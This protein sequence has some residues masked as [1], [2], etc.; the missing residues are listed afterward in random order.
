L[1]VSARDTT[2]PIVEIVELMRETCPGWDYVQL[3]EGGHMA[4][5]SH[6]E[7][8]NPIIVDFIYGRKRSSS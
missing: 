3:P 5:M 1:V 8:V 4:P 6:P 7:W 2:R